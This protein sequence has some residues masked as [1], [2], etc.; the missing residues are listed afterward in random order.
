MFWGVEDAKKVVD[1][2]RGDGAQAF[3]SSDVVLLVR[4][5]VVR[6]LVQHIQHASIGLIVDALLSLR[7]DGVPLRLDCG[8]VEAQRA[9]PVG[10]EEQRQVQLVGRQRLPEARRVH[11]G[12]PVGDAT[13]AGDEVGVLAISHVE[14][15]VE[16][17][18]LEQVGESGTSWRIVLG[19][20]VVRD[21][22]RDGGRRVILGE[23]HLEPVIERER[24]ERYAL[25]P[26]K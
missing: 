12:L 4:R 24:F 3:V 6:G 17:H 19:A 8:L 22:D 21:R 13:L 5:D 23:D 26:P 9:H 2:L 18:V 1:L 11:Q 14:R 25:V 16:Q 20:N 10:F 15:A 7:E